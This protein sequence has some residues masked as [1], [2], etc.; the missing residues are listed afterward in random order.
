MEVTQLTQEV[1]LAT[2]MTGGVSL[3][4]WMAGVAR[5]INLVTQASQARR[6]EKP[7]P[8]VIGE[9]EFAAQSRES[10][11][12]LLDLLDILVDVDVLSGTSA[13]GINAALLALSRVNGCDLGGL[14][15][16][17]LDLGALTNLIRK[18]TDKTIPSLLYGDERMLDDLMNK[19]PELK[20]GPFSQ[21][22]LDKPS[23]TVYITTTLLDGEAGEFTDSFGTLVQDVDR[24]GVFTFTEKDLASERIVP[25]LALAARSSA[26]F[27][28]AFEPAF[29]P[30]DTTVPGTNG[31]PERPAMKNYINI[32]R[33]HWAA[34]G[35]LLNNQPI[36]LLL[37]R[38]FDRH[39][40]RP[41]RRVLLFVTPTSGPELV[42]QAP[43]IKAT[44]P[45]GLV[46]GL[47]K[48]IGAVT[49]QS[50]AAD[51]RTIRAHQDRMEA[52]TDARMR[53]AEL[54]TEL[55]PASLLTLHL[56]DDYR[57]RESTK[58]AHVLA[59]ALL[60]Q[61]DTWPS[62][63]SGDDKSIP[64]NWQRQL[65]V[66]GNAAKVCGDAIKQEIIAGWTKD[67]AGLPATPAALA[68]YGQAAFGL[69]KAVALA[70]VRAA[71]ELAY[72]KKNLDALARL[73]RGIHSADQPDSEPDQLSPDQLT[74]QRSPDLAEIACDV[75][76]DTSVRAGTLKAAAEALAKRYLVESKVVEQAWAKLEQVITENRDTLTKLA[77]PAAVPDSDTSKTLDRMKLPAAL[78]LKIYVKY[79]WPENMSQT[80]TS[81]LF[82]LAATQ[83]AMLPAEADIDQP[84]EFVQVSAD[85]RSL[86]APAFSTAEQKLTGMQLHHFGAFYKRSWRANDWMWGRLDGAGWLVHVLLDPRRILRVVHTPA[87][88]R[89]EGETNAQWLIRR[90]KDIGAPHFPAGGY[91]LPITGRVTVPKLTEQTLLDELEFLDNF[92][93]AIP[94]SI[95]NT[96]L[97]LAQVWQRLVVDDELTTLAKTVLESPDGKN[98]DWS[99]ARSRSWADGVNAA[100]NKPA[101]KCA[102]LNQNPVA[103]ETF[104]TDKGSPLMAVTVT[105]AA[106]TATAAIGSIR[107]IPNVVKPPL[108]AV[109]TMALGGYRVV[110]TTSGVPK[111]FI[112]GG[113]ALL[114]LGF[115][116]AIQSVTVVGITGLVMVGVGAYLAV[117]G[118][119]QLSSR[120]LFALL[121]VTAVGS[122]LAMGTPVISRWLFGSEQRPGLLGRNVYWLG[123]QWWHPVAAIFAIAV[124]GILLGT[125]N[126]RRR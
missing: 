16:I 101:D 43:E 63:P 87:C 31:V 61:L 123:A 57:T 24:R 7:L 124:V 15:E 98:P 122:V 1:R 107:Q 84:L 99:P 20:Q 2:T 39:A 70:V 3:A 50:I 18:P 68:Q 76:T 75:C 95:P 10:Y 41:V 102:L 23:T 115:A 97:W 117:L 25:A 67:N 35:G 22:E 47:L 77:D 8:S 93:I 29:V 126:P 88:D 14:R 45:L 119:W 4:I 89:K 82:D 64:E 40:A 120:L 52:R 73:T 85:T 55:S 83:R 104:R 60:R 30:F 48:D 79:L 96:S 92:S 80:V 21:E 65:A 110:S 49:S 116:L 34:D 62:G 125:A 112:L 78:E 12:Q 114:V 53:L 28:V 33:S 32:T 105:K 51:L 19:I 71:Y 6:A 5:E 72:D 37:E 90:L 38:I 69:T 103:H 36:G 27:P 66:G 46:E 58:Q 86:L 121:S 54:A 42:E 74:A 113:A 81:R 17:W 9:E 108:S 111:R 13:G 56:L 109:R 118:T 59:T 100:K 44:A 11:R 106:A 91:E 94:S 26:S